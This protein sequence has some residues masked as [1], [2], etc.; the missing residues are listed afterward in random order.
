MVKKVVLSLLI[1]CA[2]VIF[3]GTAL[4]GNQAV[5]L[6]PFD[7]DGPCSQ[8]YRDCGGTK[9]YVVIAQFA[10]QPDGLEKL[11]DEISQQSRKI[12]RWTFLCEKNRCKVAK[13]GS[14]QVLKFYSRTIPGLAQNLGKRGVQEIHKGLKISIVLCNKDEKDFAIDQAKQAIEKANDWRL[15]VVQDDGTKKVWSKGYSV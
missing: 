4:A 12:K 11:V 14:D 5:Y 2:G 3:A 15:V 6:V 9:P 7:Y 13:N 10:Q 8:V 1:G